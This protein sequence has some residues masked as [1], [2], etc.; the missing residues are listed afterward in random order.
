MGQQ[1]SYGSHC[2]NMGPP[3][4]LSDPITVMRNTTCGDKADMQGL[5]DRLSSYIQRIRAMKQDTGAI[6]PACYHENLRILENELMKLKNMY[7]QE[8]DRLR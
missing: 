5:N 3:D 1:K 2:G 4:G 8:L 6:D 7:E